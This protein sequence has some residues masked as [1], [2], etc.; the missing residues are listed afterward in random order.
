MGINK[1]FVVKNGLEVNENLIYADGVTG[2]VGIGT[3]DPQKTLEVLGGV[4]VVDDVSIGS[5]LSV[6]SRTILGL[7]LDVASST[8]IGDTLDVASSTT[9]GDTL[10]VSGS[11]TLNSTLDV[12][13]S[14]VLDS[15]LD[16]A[17]RTN[18]SNTLDVLDS[19]NL[20]ADLT[21]D[22]PTNLNS[23]LNV[24]GSTRL[25]SSLDVYGPTQLYSFLSV[26]EAATFS[27]SVTI[28]GD[29]DNLLTINHFG[30]GSAL[31]I[32]NYKF[33]TKT[34]SFQASEGVPVVIDSYS[35]LT[36]AYNTVEY[37]LNIVNGENIQAQKVLVL[38][39]S[40]NAY[41]EEYGIIF[42][43]SPIVSVGVAITNSTCE[44][45]VV[46]EVGVVGNVEYK[47][48]RGGIE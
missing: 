30:S 20:N 19:T 31:R 7:T 39:N 41:C 14:T 21:V 25:D 34:G 16:V 43:N 46:P 18:I 45:S 3:T 8:T 22:G 5:S 48:I 44:L 17:G 10:D 9:I 11:T 29:N 13:G 42:N 40:T 23:T 4:L 2:K 27:S 6:G 38:Q 24:S 26:D 36:D 37:T 33:S 47:L 32:N 1:N 35:L 12:T 15:I 28:S